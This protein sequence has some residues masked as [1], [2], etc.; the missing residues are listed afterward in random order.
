M[1]VDWQQ[2][3]V[4]AFCKKELTC[5]GDMNMQVEPTEIR[6]L[7]KGVL[8]ECETLWQRVY[9]LFLHLFSYMWHGSGEGLHVWCAL[10]S[11]FSVFWRRWLSS[12]STVFQ[13]SL[14]KGLGKWGYLLMLLLLLRCKNSI[15]CLWGLI[16]GASFQGEKEQ[17][18][19]NKQGKV[20]SDF[21]F[22]RKKW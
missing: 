9:E 7:G 14:I 8:F 10:K 6:T 11:P 17:Q 18:L 1:K 21:I 3:T 12:P 2:W 15:G 4:I 19:I 16:C 22:L 13:L 5:V 20:S